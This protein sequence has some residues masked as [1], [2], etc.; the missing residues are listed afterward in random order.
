MKKLFLSGSVL[1]GLGIVFVILSTLQFKTREEVFRVG[2]FAASATTAKKLPA[3]RYI[4]FGC[5]GA[6]VVFL[7]LGYLQRR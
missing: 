3:F 7:G 1:V 6:G 5:L 4:G 2:N